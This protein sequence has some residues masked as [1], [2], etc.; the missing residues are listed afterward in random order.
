MRV[1]APCTTLCRIIKAGELLRREQ[2]VALQ[3]IFTLLLPP[4]P[5][6][7]FSNHSSI[8]RRKYSRCDPSISHSLLFLS[9]L[10]TE[11]NAAVHHPGDKMLE[12][13]SKLSFSTMRKVQTTS[14]ASSMEISLVRSSPS[15]RFRFVCLLCLG[16]IRL[17]NSSR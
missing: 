7:V 15:H 2:F 4:Q 3:G 17:G 13:V 11:I 16:E 1:Y 10:I 8:I 14:D 12:R 9:S 6:R 5:V